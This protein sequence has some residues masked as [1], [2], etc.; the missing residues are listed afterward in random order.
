M[1]CEHF[2]K[3]ERTSIACV[4]E[5]K[6]PRLTQ[7]LL[8]VTLSLSKLIQKNLKSVASLYRTLWVS[9]HTCPCSSG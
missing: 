8:L 2:L 1:Y 3:A 9:D 7:V 6:T 5:P 4:K